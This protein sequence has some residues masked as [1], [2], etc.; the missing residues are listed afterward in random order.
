MSYAIL[1]RWVW[2]QCSEPDRILLLPLRGEVIDGVVTADDRL[3]GE[4][5]PL[6]TGPPAELRSR[7]DFNESGD[8]IVVAN[9]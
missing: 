3:V 9:P 7:S 4:V 8:V 6:Y 1:R 2:L 5:W